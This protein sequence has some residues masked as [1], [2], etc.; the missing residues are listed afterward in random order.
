MRRDGMMIH[1]ID[2]SSGSRTEKRQ[3]K[4]PPPSWKASRCARASMFQTSPAV[5]WRSIF[6]DIPTSSQLVL[7]KKV[8]NLGKNCVR[9]YRSNFKSDFCALLVPSRPLL[10]FGRPPSGLSSERQKASF[11]DSQDEA[12]AVANMGKVARS[13]VAT[14][15][16]HLHAP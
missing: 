5:F 1:L 12:K 2:E 16:L 3:E 7:N 11:G 14:G 9:P 4:T 6:S 13:K 8:V 15:R 10:S